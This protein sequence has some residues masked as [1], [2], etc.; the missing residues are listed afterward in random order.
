VDDASEPGI[1]AD[2]NHF[3]IERP[4]AVDRTRIDLIA[5]P[6]VHGQRL[7]RDGCLVD[8][9]VSKEHA[10]VEGYFVAGPYD[11]LS[12]NTDGLNRHPGDW[13]S[14]RSRDL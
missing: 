9:A 2:T 12:A 8:V 1:S 11:D 13:Q 10:A 4:A 5:G 6:L 7:P 14:E 3:K